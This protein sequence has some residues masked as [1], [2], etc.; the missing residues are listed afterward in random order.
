M[1]LGHSAIG[2]T[3]LQAGGSRRIVGVGI[4]DVPALHSRPAVSRGARSAPTMCAGVL[5]HLSDAPGAR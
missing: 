5:G 1:G 2:E 3:E 4:G